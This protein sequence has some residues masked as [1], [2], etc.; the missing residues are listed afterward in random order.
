MNP[1]DVL[2]Y[3]QYSKRLRDLEAQKPVEQRM[4]DSQITRI[5]LERVRAGEINQSGRRVFDEVPIQASPPLERAPITRLPTPEFEHY[6]R[7]PGRVQA[8]PPPV[9]KPLS[10][11]APPPVGG[12]RITTLAYPEGVSP[13][14]FV[15]S[16]P[17]FKAMAAEARQAQADEAAQSRTRRD[18]RLLRSSM[19]GSR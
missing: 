14:E 10:V 12:A 13:E 2:K 9:A 4:D 1:D 16:G 15:A 11:A 19:R 7:M 8:A 5:A 3:H 17:D 18:D 6:K